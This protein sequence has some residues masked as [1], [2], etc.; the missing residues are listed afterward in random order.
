MVHLNGVRR[1]RRPGSVTAPDR[2]LPGADRATEIA[3]QLC[4]GLHAAHEE[5]SSAQGSQARQYHDRWAGKAAHYR[6]WPGRDRRRR[7]PRTTF[8]AGLRPTCRPSNWPAAKSRRAATST[9]W[10]L[11]LHE[12]YTGKQVWRSN[13][14]ANLVAQRSDESPLSPSSHVDLDP[15]VDAVIQRCLEPSPEKRPST[16]INVLASLPGGDPL[17]AALAAG[18]TP[19]PE[20]VADAGE[21]GRAPLALGIGLFAAVCVLLAIIPIVADLAHWVNLSDYQEF[22][23]TVLEQNAKDWISRLDLNSGRNDSVY[24]Y[25]PG[26]GNGRPLEF[27]YRQHSGRLVPQLRYPTAS[28]LNWQVTVTDPSPLVPGMLSVRL[29][30]NKRFDSGQQLLELLAIPTSTSTPASANAQP[31]WSNLLKLVGL[32]PARMERVPEAQWPKNSRPPLYAEAVSVWKHPDSPDDQCL[33]ASLGGK[34][35]YFCRGVNDLGN[36]Q[37]IF[38][39]QDE[40][41]NGLR[42]DVGGF[43]AGVVNALFTLFLGCATLLAFYNLR[44]GRSDTRG[45]LR[46]TLSFFLFDLALRT[47]AVHH[48]ADFGREA[49]FAFDALIFSTAI[50]FRISI[51]YVALEPFVRRRWPELLISWSRLLD[52]RIRDPLFGRDVLVGCLVGA[53]W[54]LATAGLYQP[55]TVPLTIG[56]HGPLHVLLWLQFMLKGAIY[57]LGLLLIASFAFPKKWHLAVVFVILHTMFYAPSNDPIGLLV[58]GVWASIVFVLFVRFGLITVMS[59]GF[60]AFLLLFVPLTASFTSWYGQPCAFALVTVVCLA[61]YAFYVSTL[62]GRFAALPTQTA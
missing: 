54:A 27:W 17:R 23:P 43:R 45:A 37:P 11:I 49:Y 8:A 13:S 15:L 32:D 9:R 22:Q 39:Q 12:I 52:G 3:R 26:Q 20:M 2:P 55:I 36:F 21:S 44:M 38:S 41:P 30:A 19:S 47:T 40:R 14:L 16:V 4:L 57:W 28:H 59:T 46:F 1:R 51:Y 6:F 50:T 10:A 7:S 35:V 29:A 53:S 24:G 5:G 61:G 34:L 42:A 56:A 62:A 18:E 48:A 33:L 60:T 25:S 31:E 58:S